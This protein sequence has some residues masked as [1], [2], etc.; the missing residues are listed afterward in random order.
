[1]ISLASEAFLQAL[2]QMSVED[3]CNRAGQEGLEGGYALNTDFTI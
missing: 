2:D 1:M 3:L